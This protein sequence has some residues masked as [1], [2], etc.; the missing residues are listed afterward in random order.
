MAQPVNSSDELVNT[1]QE[2]EGINV[3]PNV[4]VL[5]DLVQDNNSANSS[6]P[7]ILSPE[8][9]T[10]HISVINSTLN[11]VFFQMKQQFTAMFEGQDKICSTLTSVVNNQDE[12]SA[13]LSQV[14]SNQTAVSTKLSEVQ[15]EVNS[16]L[17]EV[18]DNVNKRLS[19]VADAQEA[20]NKT[21]D[22][23][24]TRLNEVSLEV[25]KKLRKLEEKL[26]RN[27]TERFEKESRAL[28]EKDQELE[29][30]VT[31]RVSEQLSRQQ[32]DFDEQL[33]NVRDF[34]QSVVSAG[35]SSEKESELSKQVNELANE[36]SKVRDSINN[37]RTEKT[38]C[39]SDTNEKQSGPY[40]TT[41][42][43]RM[44]RFNDSSVVSCGGQECARHVDESFLRL[45][46][47]QYF[48]ADKNSVHPV[49]FIKSFENVFPCTWTE[50]EKIQYICGYI[51]GHAS[52]WALDV[53][54]SCATV[55]DF[56][57]K[58]LDKHWS[59]TV[60][61]RLR[62]EV[63]SPEPFDYKRGTLRKYFEK[64]VD[65]T[66]YWTDP[67]SHRDL[68]RIL[69][70]QLPED[71]Q[72][73]LINISEVDLEQFLVTLDAI[74]LIYERKRTRT[75]NE[76]RRAEFSDEEGS[77]SSSG[78]V[79][80]KRQKQQKK[81]W[82]P[83]GNSKFFNKNQQQQNTGGQ[84]SQQQGFQRKPW[85]QPNVF[86]TDFVPPENQNKDSQKGNQERPQ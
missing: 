44:D 86:A 56:E 70:A 79:N 53:I 32:K 18:Q 2:Q 51:Q 30:R 39:Q 55:A 75:Q 78:P 64:Y 7:R 58:F 6:E 72:V 20:L 9:V 62:R 17:E 50:R 49:V 26:S 63:F 15:G 5:N 65:K 84:F 45:R 67:L 73:K 81:K 3:A 13:K 76:K 36:L 40:L 80:F 68:I 14:Q 1:A 46:Q 43:V 10:K 85:N 24:A 29:K 41:N 42:T 59:A 23:L 66:R 71:I 82:K 34:V 69:K 74:D 37:S 38:V 47:F 16:K 21:V 22:S 8:E 28:I 83:Y 27:M 35:A 57:R 31:E 25:D 12:V 60:Q 33:S 77:K 4:N 48:T 11:T 54:Q 52:L 61:E 19:K